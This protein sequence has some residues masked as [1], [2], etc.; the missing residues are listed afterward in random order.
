MRK[1]LLLALL[2]APALALASFNIVAPSAQPIGGPTQSLLVNATITASSDIEIT[3]LSSNKVTLIY[4]IVTATSGTLTFTI[5]EADPQNPTTVLSG[6]QTAT[7]GSLSSAGTGQVTISGVTSSAVKV[8]WTAAGGPNFSGVY[9]SLVGRTVATGGSAFSDAGITDPYLGLWIADGGAFGTLGSNTGL[10]KLGSGGLPISGAAAP[11]GTAVSVNNPGGAVGGTGYTLLFLDNT[12]PTL[13][14]TG[15]GHLVT[16]SS[17]AK[18]STPLAGVFNG[19]FATVGQVNTISVNGADLSFQLTFTTGTGTAT[20]VAGSSLVA[21][22]LGQA[23]SSTQ[24]VCHANY[25]VNPGTAAEQT[26]MHCGLTAANTVTIYN[27]IGFTPTVA[28]TSYV[29][30]V[31]LTGAGATY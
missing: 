13:A 21:I 24:V 2:L 7:T 27:D 17:A 12:L 3:N 25:G 29:Y 31:T 30:S 9:L 23:Y 26:S 16:L 10:S 6:G 20:I 11:G 18:P 19:N 15:A 4:N 5:A 1:L 14:V 22:T 8:S 28:P